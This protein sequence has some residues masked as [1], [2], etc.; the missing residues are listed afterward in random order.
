LTSNWNT[1][2]SFDKKIVST[3]AKRGVIKF[4][5]T[6]IAKDYAIDQSGELQRNG[7]LMKSDNN[8]Y[9]ILASNDSTLY[10]ARTEITLK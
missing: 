8:K 4:D 1:K 10:H 5:I 9:N 7:L 6:D 3:N 2:I